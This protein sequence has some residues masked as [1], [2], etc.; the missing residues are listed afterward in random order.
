[1]HAIM[2]VCVCKKSAS[3]YFKYN[4]CVGLLILPYVE[5]G[6]ESSTFQHLFSPLPS[7]SLFSSL[8]HRWSTSLRPRPPVEVASHEGGRDVRI[9]VDIYVQR[10]NQIS[11]RQ[12]SFMSSDWRCLFLFSS[13]YFIFLL[14]AATPL[15]P[16]SL[17]CHFL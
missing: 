15:R 12:S 5:T 3:S 14:Y 9:I 7:P 16:P 13:S 17:S 1:M 8:T 10:R 11:E 2:Y 6:R 4:F